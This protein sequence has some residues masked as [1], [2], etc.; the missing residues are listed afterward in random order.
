MREA[1]IITIARGVAVEKT[2]SDIHRIFIRKN[3]KNSI[4]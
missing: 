1:E 2:G 4:L 3:M